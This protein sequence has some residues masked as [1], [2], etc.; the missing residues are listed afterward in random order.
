MGIGGARQFKA[1]GET[2]YL[3]FQVGMEVRRC[4]KVQ[5]GSEVWSFRGR[6][7]V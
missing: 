3:G 1:T 6:K 2:K 5:R 4:V 7:G